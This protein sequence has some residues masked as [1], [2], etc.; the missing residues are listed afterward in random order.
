[1]IINY[2]TKTT[3]NENVYDNDNK[4]NTSNVYYFFLEKENKKTRRDILKKQPALQQRNEDFTRVLYLMSRS[5][6]TKPSE[7][8]I[9]TGRNSVGKNLA[10][11]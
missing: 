7:T 8:S 2:S 11:A 3:I 1:M 4:Y 9:T 6:V 10:K 5:M